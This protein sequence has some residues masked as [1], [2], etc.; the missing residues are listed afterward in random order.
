MLPSWLASGPIGQQFGYI[1][2]KVVKF[3]SYLQNKEKR[4]RNCPRF[5]LVLC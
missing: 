1:K 3:Y 2:I 5:F 4:R